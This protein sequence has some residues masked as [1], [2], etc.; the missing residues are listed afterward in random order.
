MIQLELTQT[1]FLE[2]KP[3]LSPI[4]SLSPPTRLP[5]PPLPA[6]PNPSPPRPV[7]RRIT[8]ALISA[9]SRPTALDSRPPG[10]GVLG[11]WASD[12]GVLRS[13]VGSCAIRVRTRMGAMWRC[14]PGLRKRFCFWGLQGDEGFMTIRM[15]ISSS[16]L[17]V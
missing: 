11:R 3:I 5:P 14:R 10:V 8:K 16:T 9:A 2:E 17:F 7:P 4:L 15:R 6:L 1:S 12:V 13:A